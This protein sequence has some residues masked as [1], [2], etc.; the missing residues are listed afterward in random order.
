[1]CKYCNLYTPD[2]YQ[3]DI[4]QTICLNCEGESGYAS[5]SIE[6][7]C[8]RGK[9]LTLQPYKHSH[10]CS[11]ARYK[12]KLMQPYTYDNV[13]KNIIRKPPELHED[14]SRNLSLNWYKE[15][16]WWYGKIKKT[17]DQY[18]PTDVLNKS[19]FAV[20]NY[21]FI[22]DFSFYIP[23]NCFMNCFPDCEYLS[24]STNG[25]PEYPIKI[26]LN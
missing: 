3:F 4:S 2:I 6:S 19:E 17:V 12:K 16:L 15:H 11:I 9:C 21:G 7:P 26:K 25:I 22:M 18:L 13:V 20:K 1:M 10:T 23:L 24:T 14:Y 5:Y 8:G